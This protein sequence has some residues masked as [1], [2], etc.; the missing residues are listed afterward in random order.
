MSF[1]CG[2][3]DTGYPKKSYNSQE[4]HAKSTFVVLATV[5]ILLLSPFSEVALVLVLRDSLDVPLNLF[6][7]GP[8]KALCA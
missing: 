6:C 2:G 8:A 5:E 7:N 4:I 3:T 1:I